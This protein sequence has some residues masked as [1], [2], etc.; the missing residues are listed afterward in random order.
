MKTKDA[1]THG[2]LVP[3]LF[4][5][6]LA[7]IVSLLSS[8]QMLQDMTPTESTQGEYI[9]IEFR[10]FVSGVYVDELANKYVQVDCRF[11]S[12]M[13]GTLPGGFSP[14]RYMSFIGVAPSLQG[15]IESPEILNIV[16]PK[17]L[18][19]IVFSFKYGDSIRIKGRAIVVF[20][21]R[22]GGPT[23]K[24]LMIQANVVEKL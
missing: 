22:M 4:G 15:Q 17:D 12:T 10:K 24:S 23:F 9:P 6:S 7:L 11:N 18:A 21:Q 1:R 16:V 8:C 20:K 14:S 2:N 3:A 19:D 13:A 5:L